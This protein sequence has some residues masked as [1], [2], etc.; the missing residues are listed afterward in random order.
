MTV[1]LEIA[2]FATASN[3]FHAIVRPMPFNI[4]DAFSEFVLLLVVAA[5]VGAMA[6]RLRQPLVVGF[7]AVGILAGPSGL[8]WIK[9][10]D[11]IHVLAEM[12]LAL[13]L[14]VVG[15]KLDLH[16]I[17]TMGMVAVKAGLAQVAVTLALGF[18]LVLALGLSPVS[19]LYVALA[20]T[21]S[22]TII[23]VKL[24][25]DKQETESLQGRLTLG[26][27]IV[28][29]LVVVLAM[30]ALSA[31]SG[32]VTTHP[33]LHA[34]LIVANGAAFLGGVWAVTVFVL[35]RILP[36]LSRSTE[37][38]VLISIAWALILALLGELMGFG[39]EVGAFLAGISLASTPYRDILAAKLASLRDFLLLFFFIE[40][41]SQLD[42]SSMGAQIGQSLVLIAFVL[43]VKPGL[44]T[45]IM[46]RMGY[47]PRTGFMVGLY[48]AQI[49]EFS[50][51]LMAMGAAAGHVVGGTV[52]VVTLVG[53]VTIGLSSYLIEHSQRIYDRSAPFLSSLDRSPRHREDDAAGGEQGHADIILVGIGPYGS[54]IAEN[55]QARGRSVL[56]VDFDPQAVGAWTG[57]G[58]SAVFGDVQDPDFAAT[59]PLLTARWVV[60][61]VRD[62]QS[63]IALVR[64]LRHAGYAGNFAFTARTRD[65]G[66]VLLDTSPGLLLVPFEDSAI[67][68]V[69]MLFVTEDRIAR[70]TMDKLIEQITGH[71]V[72][73]G[74]GRMG[75]QVVKDFLRQSV[76]F[77]VVEDNPEQLPKLQEANLPHVVGNAS[78]DDVLIKAGIKRAKGLISVASTDE[79]NVFIVLTARV[80]NPNLYIVARSILEEN[81]DKLR[82]AGADKVM[83]PYILGGHRIATAVTKPGIFEF[84]DLLMHSDKLPIEIG[85]VTLNPS[86][87]LNAR[88]VAEI[89][90]GEIYGVT[91]LAVRRPGV[92]LHA[93]PRGDYRL[94]AGDELIVIGTVEQIEAIEAATTP[95][96][97]TGANLA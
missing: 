79:A 69:D 38:L 87:P 40:M 14:F 74:Y 12:G 31:V 37:L 22:S 11:Q 56:G 23:I 80:L 26:V 63:N 33:V 20:L 3:G 4:H 5:L 77:V 9:S 29:D 13:L 86:S 21:L 24:L 34:L 52:G 97:G 73:C 50:L 71:I 81:E 32:T 45:V 53:L 30:I 90:L 44:V 68:A 85:I 70:E 19:A 51:I 18:I 94:E 84:L 25:S 47:R 39:K 61:A 15:L 67:Q 16:I 35:P 83:S 95:D 54:N 36:F 89:D 27:L 28:Q 96:G 10:S 48:L 55:L 7:I 88:T 64:S 8:H 1:A 65:E 6:A 62:Q 59:L 82:R 76:P 75:Q 78:Q 2:I 57:R 93:N 42:V 17:R 58:W 72:V 43:F 49:S 46:T 92:Q 91:L 66:Q 41:G 60:S